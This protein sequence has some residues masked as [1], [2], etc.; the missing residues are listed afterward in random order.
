MPYFLILCVTDHKCSLL[1]SSNMQ[2]LLSWSLDGDVKNSWGIDPCGYSSYTLPWKSLSF[3]SI[4]TSRNESF[5]LLPFSIV[6]CIAGWC[7]LRC[8]WKV[9]SSSILWGHNTNVSSMCLSQTDC[10]STANFNA[11]F[12]K[13]S[14]NK[15]ANTDNSGE[16][17]AALT[18]CSK[19]VSSSMK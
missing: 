6:N 10:H 8:W 1:F 13:A 4:W 18:T 12:S 3:L 5:P 9:P 14:M 19:N 11:I 15:F 2:W 7:E 16:R 17:M